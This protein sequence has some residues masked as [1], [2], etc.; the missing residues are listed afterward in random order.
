[1]DDKLSLEIPRDRYATFDPQL[2]GMHHQDSFSAKHCNSLG[3]GN[4]TQ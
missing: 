4:E 3:N 1:M 2:I